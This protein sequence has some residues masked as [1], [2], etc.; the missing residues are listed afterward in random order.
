[1]NVLCRKS[2]WFYDKNLMS[3]LRTMP[4]SGGNDDQVE[5]FRQVDCFQRDVLNMLEVGMMFGR[6]GKEPVMSEAGCLLKGSRSV[7]PLS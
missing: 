7:R 5:P 2:N 6:S 4:N 3:K 1:M